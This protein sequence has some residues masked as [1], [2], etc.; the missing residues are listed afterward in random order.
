[1]GISRSSQLIRLHFLVG[2]AIAGLAFVHAW[3]SMRPEI[4]GRA[5]RRD[6][7]CSLGVEL[8]SHLDQSLITAGLT[9]G[10]TAGPAPS[11]TAPA[12]S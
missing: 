8:G 2:Y 1:V 11:S 9:A 12:R 6:D 5:D 4:A 10:L 7:A 3:V